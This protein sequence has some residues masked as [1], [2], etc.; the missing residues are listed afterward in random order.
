[1]TAWSWSSRHYVLKYRF[2]H[3]QPHS[4]TSWQTRI[5]SDTTARTCMTI[6][7]WKG[8]GW[9]GFTCK[10]KFTVLLPYKRQSPSCYCI[11]LISITHIITY[12]FLWMCVWHCLLLHNSTWMKCSFIHTVSYFCD[13][14]V[15]SAQGPAKTLH[16]LSYWNPS[17]LF[18]SVW[19][20]WKQLWG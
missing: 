13:S 2:V 4:V 20:S 18:V 19:V 11:L 15:I 9:G 5:F 7:F 17:W 12:G 6:V 10:W 14:P 3:S 16:L 1:M 8:D